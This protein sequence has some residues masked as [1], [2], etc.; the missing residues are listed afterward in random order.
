[1]AP[2]RQ[3]F[4]CSPKATASE[5]TPQPGAVASPL[6]YAALPLRVDPS[7]PLAKGPGAGADEAGEPRPGSMRRLGEGRRRDADL[8]LCSPA[9]PL[10]RGPVSPGGG[11]GQAC[12]Q[13]RVPA[14]RG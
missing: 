13:P 2:P 8:H 6:P 12:V 4:P 7:A 5:D 1:M 3:L 9:R 14:P 11:P 10:R